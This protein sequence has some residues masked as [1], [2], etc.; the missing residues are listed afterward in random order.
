MTFPV[1]AF[2][3]NLI[4]WSWN[5]SFAIPVDDPCLWPINYTINFHFIVNDDDNKTIHF[6][7]FCIDKDEWIRVEVCGMSLFSGWLNMKTV[8]IVLNVICLKSSCLLVVFGNITCIKQT[9]TENLSNKHT[10]FV[11]WHVRYG[12]NR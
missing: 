8:Y 1:L 7:I 3:M 6:M 2:V 4:N 12:G 9:F 11:N 5:G 10:H